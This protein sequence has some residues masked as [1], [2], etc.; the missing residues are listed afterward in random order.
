MS[1]DSKNRALIV[2]GDKTAEEIVCVAREVY[3][4]QFAEIHK[5]IFD[6]RIDQNVEFHDLISSPSKSRLYCW[7]H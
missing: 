4:D 2:F 6:D 3:C 7:N 1:F 5:F